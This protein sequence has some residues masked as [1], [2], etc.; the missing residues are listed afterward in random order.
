MILV[1]TSVWVDHLRK[2]NKNLAGL[3]EQQQVLIHSMIIGEL[4]CGNLTNRDEILKLLGNLPTSKKASDN[5]VLYFIEQNNLMGRGI[6]FIDF[7]LLVSAA[8]THPAVL[9]TVDRRL[10][11]IAEEMNLS[12]T[13][14]GQK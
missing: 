4:A 9:W 11:K 13:K 6:G 14:N 2:G 3:L 5:E 8:L 7:H 12:Y 1:D 10:G